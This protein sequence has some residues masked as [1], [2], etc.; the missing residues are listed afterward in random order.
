MPRLV[1][2]KPA[3]LAVFKSS[4][5][6]LGRA[7][8]LLA[9]VFL[10]SVRG[11]KSEERV[12]DH[13]F[14]ILERTDPVVRKVMGLFAYRFDLLSVPMATMLARL[15]DRIPHLDTQVAVQVIE[16][17]L[18]APLD[19][20]FSAFDPEPLGSRVLRSTYQGVLRDG[21]EVIVRIRPPGMRQRLVDELTA[22][23][24]LLA[25]LELFTVVRPGFFGY[26]RTENANILMEEADFRHQAR[27]QRLFQKRVRRD[28]L[29]FATV[30]PLYEEWVSDNLMI[31]GR[32]EGVW[33][34]EV[35]S[36][37]ESGD[38]QK[39]QWLESKGIV[40]E[41]LARR[42]VQLGWW[43]Q[44]EHLFFQAA[45]IPAD[46]VVEPD[47][48]LAVMHFTTTATTTSRHRRLLKDLQARVADEDPS[49][50]TEVLIQ[51]LI[52]MPFID[53]HAFF[54]R[55]EARV[56]H[57]ILA[58]HD[59]QARWWERTSVGL[60]AALL[61][62][63]REERIQVH[64]E[65]IHLMRASMM[66]EGM[67]FRLNPRIDLVKEFRRYR[68]KADRRTARR[69]G[70]EI[71][72]TFGNDPRIAIA[73]RLSE[74]ASLVQRMGSFVETRLE[75]LP[76]TNLAMPRKAAY[77][78][79]VILQSLTLGLLIA[80]AGVGGRVLSTVVTSGDI[81]LSASTLWVFQNPVYIGIAS[82]L[83]LISI[84]RIMFRL[85]DKDQETERQ[86]R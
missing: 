75:S 50:A 72:R 51:F 81:D 68:R 19:T 76:I 66:V 64:L 16:R 24:R 41:Q 1:I 54:K 44:I 10:D 6:W 30:A 29:D 48:R 12:A 37:I 34:P 2:P 20:V 61:V 82:M 33:L 63:T 83:G 84:R 3:R 13:F 39:L 27:S 17:G 77:A 49:G 43:E 71:T 26:L 7:C 45:P 9:L 36:I 56:W 58:M 62:A 18:G 8:W 55:V 86:Q 25:V 85:G 74:T 28:K 23:E 14:T 78:V 31:V 80:M 53:T 47:G 22:L 15:D 65:V 73:A 11:R 32:V 67:A 38:K 79:S 5:R 57:Q 42:L 52:P 21:S 59:R 35:I 60:W 40:P 70:R 69:L 46:I 4:L